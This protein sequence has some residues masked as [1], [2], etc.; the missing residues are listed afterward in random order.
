M[1]YNARPSSQ[2]PPCLPSAP[3][4]AM[5]RVM[6]RV[7]RATQTTLSTWNYACMVQTNRSWEILPA[8]S[9]AL[10]LHKPLI[11]SPPP[12]GEGRNKTWL[13]RRGIGSGST[14]ANAHLQMGSNPPAKHPAEHRALSV[15]ACN[16]LVRSV[17]PVQSARNSMVLRAEI[18]FMLASLHYTFLYIYIF[19]SLKEIFLDKF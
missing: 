13:E 19:A 15:P 4:W 9:R 14:R 18:A 6:Q 5:L 7:A 16:N 3:N 12:S 1:G 10:Q 11:P 2:C 17:V 8:V